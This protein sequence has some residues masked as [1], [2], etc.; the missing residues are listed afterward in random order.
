MNNH[1]AAAALVC[2]FAPLKLS[3]FIVDG[4]LIAC[5]FSAKYK[6]PTARPKEVTPYLSLSKVKVWCPILCSNVSTSSV[7]DCVCFD[8]HFC[9]APVYI[10]RCKWV[11]QPGSHRRKITHEFFFL[12]VQDKHRRRF[13]ASS[14]GGSYCSCFSC[15]AIGN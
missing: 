13:F 5:F 12:E 14:H 6:R 8:P 11:Y 3:L 10:F 2:Y 4:G 1:A 7:F 9:W 15:K